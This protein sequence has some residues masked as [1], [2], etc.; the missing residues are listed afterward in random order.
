MAPDTPTRTQRILGSTWSRAGTAVALVAS[1]VALAFTLWPGLKP[2]PRGVLAARMKVETLEPHVTLASFVRRFHPGQLRAV[3][4]VGETLQGYVIY[5]RVQIDG[6]KH[7]NV[8][9]DN[10]T[11]GW[12]SRRPFSDRPAANARGFRP[13]TPSD[14]WV[15]VVWVADPQ[16][17]RDFF[18]RLRLFDGDI[19]LAFADTPRIPA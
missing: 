11:Y 9:L 6:K 15:A 14:Q 17:G 4:D 8:S 5:L 19:L 13:D 2:D 7:D 1:V 18:V 16:E 10:V 12:R 3:G